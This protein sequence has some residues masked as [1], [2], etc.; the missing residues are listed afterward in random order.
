MAVLI[1]QAG[2]LEFVGEHDTGKTLAML[3]AVYPYEKTV[4]VDDDTKGSSI[5]QQMVKQRIKFADYINMGKMRAELGKTPTPK[6]LL[7]DVVEPVVDRILRIAAKQGRLDAI[8]WDTWRTVYQAHRMYVERNQHEFRDVVKWQGSSNIVQGLISRVARIA[9]LSIINKLQEVAD[10]VMISHHIKAHYVQNVEVGVI[11]ESSSTFAEVCSMRVWL[12]RNP[13]SKIPIMLFLKR[14][15]M[16]KLVPGKGMKFVNIVPMKVVP[17]ASDESIWD[18][19][20]RYEKNP[21][22]SRPATAEETPTKEELQLIK[23]TLSDD[24]K[25]YALEVMKRQKL[26]E[27][28]IISAVQASRVAEGVP[29]TGMELISMAERMFKMDI[30]RVIEV[31]GV[32]EDT[33]MDLEGSDVRAA[34]QAVQEAAEGDEVDEVLDSAPAKKE[35]SAANGKA[36]KSKAKSKR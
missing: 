7:D 20:R 36:G 26:E 21:I 22:E 5:V 30:D 25:E 1:N 13:N 3:Q 28:A 23:G 33:L 9:E 2:I 17:T 14:P 11:P 24:Q 10:L 32:D 12:R 18:A 35:K 31:T 6:Q 4:F 16:P 34:W 15:T 29:V 8:I 19:V 27:T